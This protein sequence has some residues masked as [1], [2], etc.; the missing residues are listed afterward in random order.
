VQK[1]KKKKS[2]KQHKQCRYFKV[3]TVIGTGKFRTF[4]KAVWNVRGLT[5][6]LRVGKLWRCGDGLFFEV[7]SLAS[8]ALLTTHHPLL[9]NVLQTG[10]RM[11]QEKS[12]TGGFDHRAPFSWLE[13]P[14]N[15][16][17]ARSGLYD[18]CSNGVSPV[19]VSASIATFQTRNADAPLRLFRHPKKGSFKTTL[20]PLSRS[21]WSV[22]R[23]S[24]LAKGSTSK[25]RPSLHLHKVPPQSNK[26]S[27]RT[28]Q[29]TLVIWLV[30]YERWYQH[31][32]HTKY[33]GLMKT[34]YV[35]WLHMWNL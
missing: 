5:S 16:M 35:M 8:D 2:W 17:K 32:G 10:G 7:P 1:K 33:F 34:P 31:G 20:T 30:F 12:G 9:E 27:P 23:S 24:P 14:T 15:H 18:G 11:F 22:I 19:S 25:K 3:S 29:T 28:L 4:A 26:S 13:K 21:G 6:L